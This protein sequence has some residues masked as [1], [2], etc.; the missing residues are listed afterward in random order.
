MP[1]ID[2]PG[3]AAVG[4]KPC[5]TCVDFK[6]WMKQQRKSVTTTAATVRRI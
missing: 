1:V 3:S 6:T 5:R 4:E 2:T